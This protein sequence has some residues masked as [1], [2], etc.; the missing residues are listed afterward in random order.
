[1]SS[2]KSVLNPQ[3]EIFETA[4]FDDSVSN[5]IFRKYEP[6]VALSEN[7]T[8]VVINV[9]DLKEYLNLSNSFIEIRGNFCRVGGGALQAGDRP[10]LEC[11]ATSIFNQSRLRINQVL[12]EDNFSLSHHNS[13]IKQLVSQSKDYN[14]TLGRNSGFILDRG[15]GTALVGA[16]SSEV[17]NSIT[18]PAGGFVN[19]TTYNIDASS[20]FNEGYNTRRQEALGGFNVNSPT[21]VVKKSYVV[22]LSDLFSFASVNKVLKGCTIRIELGLR[23][24]LERM[25]QST[26]TGIFSV[27]NCDLYLAVVEPSLETLSSLESALASPTEIPYSYINWKTYQSDTLNATSRSY[28]FSVQSQKPVCAFIYAQRTSV[29]ASDDLFNS[30]IYD[31]AL[32]SSVQ[33]RVN[34]KLFPYQPFEPVFGMTDAGVNTT[35]SYVARPYEELLKYMQKNYNVDSGALITQK[36]WENLYPIYH[37]NFGSLPDANSYQL[38]LDVRTNGT[39]ANNYGTRGQSLT[40]YMTLCTLAQV[41]IRSDGNGMSIIAM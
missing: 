38:T 5:T 25:F 24:T 32:V 33:M 17:Q 20:T 10:A 28:T 4:S 21:T 41:S 15:N 16:V 9:R 39:L 26:N 31:S 12:V 30:M 7:S 8:Q 34:N 23:S 18:S 19:A 3:F 2:L 11:G 22:R 13:H 35:G 37:I 40:F 1:M 36:E 6:D 27:T 14:D 29:A